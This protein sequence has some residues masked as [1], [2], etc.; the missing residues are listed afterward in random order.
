MS[1]REASMR[2]GMTVAG[3]RARL[4]SIRHDYRRHRRRCLAREGRRLGTPDGVVAA[5][6][7]QSVAVSGTRIGMIKANVLYA[8]E[9]YSPAD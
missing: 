1:K 2:L 8:K 7:V 3:T 4:R 6:G 9:L 5:T